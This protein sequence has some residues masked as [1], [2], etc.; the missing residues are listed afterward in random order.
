M[1]LK[2]CVKNVQTAGYNGARALVQNLVFQGLVLDFSLELVSLSF[3]S[4]INY[5]KNPYLFIH[6]Y[7]LL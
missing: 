1:V 4:K 2:K 5:L 3:F 7:M 6:T